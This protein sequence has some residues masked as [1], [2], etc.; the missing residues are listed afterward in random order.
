[1]QVNAIKDPQPRMAMMSQDR[2]VL[3]IKFFERLSSLCE[4]LYIKFSGCPKVAKRCTVFGTYK[5]KPLTIRALCQSY[6]DA[7]S[8]FYRHCERMELPRP[9][10]ELVESSD[11]DF[12]A[13]YTAIVNEAE[14]PEPLASSAQVPRTAK[15]WW[16]LWNEINFYSESYGLT[17]DATQ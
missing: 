3:A 9:L 7:M 11:I 14:P 8:P 15:E 2:D 16:D 5:D 12:M 6:H 4:K 10:I 1:M 13:K 17:A